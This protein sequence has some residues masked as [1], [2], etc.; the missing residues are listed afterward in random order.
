M[1][2]VRK[3]GT[4]NIHVDDWKMAGRLVPISVYYTYLHK[5]GKKSKCKTAVHIVIVACERD[6]L[7]DIN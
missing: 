6:I 1:K 3:E 5:K 4:A 7:A 2:Q